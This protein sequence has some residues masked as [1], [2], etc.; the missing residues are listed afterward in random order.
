MKY[1]YYVLICFLPITSSFAQWSNQGLSHLTVN[2]LTLHEDTLYACTNDGIYKRSTELSDTNWAQT[3]FA[4]KT[5][6]NLLFIDRNECLSLVEEG[7]GPNRLVYIHKSS[8]RAHTFSLFYDTPASPTI[9]SYL[10]HMDKGS[11]KDTL[12]FL[13]HDLKTYDGGRT[14][15]PLGIPYHKKKFLQAHPGNANEI[16]AGGENGF[17]WP[18]LY[19]TANSGQSWEDIPV[20]LHGD[21]AIHVLCIRGDDWYAACEGY[22]IHKKDTA[23]TW[24][25]L[26][27]TFS[28]PVWSAYYYG[29][30]LSP[31]NENYLYVSGASRSSKIHMLISAD[32]G[33]TWDSLMY[34]PGLLPRYDIVELLV[35][36][37]D[38][39]DIIWLAG[40]GVYAYSTAVPLGVDVTPLARFKVYPNPV[41]DLLHVEL[42]GNSPNAQ[43]MLVDGMGHILLRKTVRSRREWLDVRDIQ[44]GVYSVRVIEDG[45]SVT[46]KKV[47]IY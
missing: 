12:Y 1:I 40:N 22:V 24:R 2:Q 3:A 13:D 5:V 38:R 20:F 36:H 34:D 43:V 8:D 18:Q 29:L 6:A 45:K 47:L 16:F 15:Q 39:N 23:S 7:T 33:N 31:V 25:I 14:W 41:T 28:D 4:G 35:Q 10:K 42:A 9:Y 21:N 26:L 17:F 30:A 11:G 32:K 27:N 37:S 44:P 46:V 19:H